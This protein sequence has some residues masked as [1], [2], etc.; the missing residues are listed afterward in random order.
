MPGMALGGIRT[1]NLLNGHSPHAS[2][3]ESK[4]GEGAKFLVTIPY[5][6]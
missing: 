1:E 3:D 6:I 2:E 5:R 4:E